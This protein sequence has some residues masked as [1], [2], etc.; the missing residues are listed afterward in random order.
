[1]HWWTC[2]LPQMRV[3]QKNN[4]THNDLCPHAMA[5]GSFWKHD[6]YSGKIIEKKFFST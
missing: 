1:M 2:K 4:S 5:P 6:R 3:S